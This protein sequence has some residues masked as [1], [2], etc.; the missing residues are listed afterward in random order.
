MRILTVAL[1]AVL[2]RSD[3]AAI[4]L[5]DAAQA[6]C[7]D[8]GDFTSY[9]TIWAAADG[10]GVDTVGPFMLDKAGITTDV[11]SD[12]LTADDLT[13]EE[14]AALIVV[15]DE[16]ENGDEIRLEYLVTEDGMKA[17]QSAYESANG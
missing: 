11:H 14:V 2:C 10:L 8:P 9:D 5:A 4:Q 16:I 13:E 15:G 3:S 6:G 1:A 7:T 17:C 12:D